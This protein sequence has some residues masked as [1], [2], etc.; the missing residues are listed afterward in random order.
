MKQIPVNLRQPHGR[1]ALPPAAEVFLAVRYVLAH[2]Q[3][4]ARIHSFRLRRT[5]GVRGKSQKRGF[6]FFGKFYDIK[7]AGNTKF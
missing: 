3:K 4:I 5:C 1:V 2:V 6:G 7:S